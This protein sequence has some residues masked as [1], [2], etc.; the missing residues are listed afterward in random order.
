MTQL[1]VSNRLDKAEVLARIE[2]HLNLHFFKTELQ[3]ASMTTV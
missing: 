1:M 2:T 3:P